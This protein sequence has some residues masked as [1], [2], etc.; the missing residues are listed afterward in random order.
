MLDEF[1]IDVVR[2]LTDP[3]ELQEICRRD[4]SIHYEGF[5]Q[6]WSGKITHDLDMTWESSWKELGRILEALGN[7]LSH[8]LTVQKRF[9]EGCFVDF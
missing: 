7:T 4:T 9:G 5:L 2:C 6:G 8:V 1:W 3:G